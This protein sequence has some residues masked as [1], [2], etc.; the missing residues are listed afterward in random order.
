MSLKQIAAIGLTIATTLAAGSALAGTK[1]TLMYTASA[2]FASA[3]VAKDQGFF[4]KHG[5]DVEMKLVQNGSVIITGVASGSA[6][7]GIPTP[8]VAFQAIDNGIELQSFA[9]TNAFP[10]TS[11]A[12]LVVSEKS[13]IFKPSDMTGKKIGVPGVG[14]LLDVVM[15]QWVDANGGNSK[16]INIVEISLPQTGDMLR[17][18]QVDGVAAVDPFAT[19]AVETGAGRLI[20]NYFDVIPTGTAAGIFVTTEAWAKANPEAIKGM[21]L[22]L[23]EA[24]NYIKSNDASARDSLAKYTTLPPAVVAKLTWPN[25]STHLTPER[26][27]F[28]KTLSQE[29]G[30]ITGD[31]DLEAFVIPYPGK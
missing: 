8:T 31:I 23:D 2:P 24:I 17:A 15:R 7:V 18:G 10:D 21:Q 12:G 6:Q 20:G 1:V 11:A 30:L 29:Q 5:V 4:E 19:R 26:L 3:F 22:A 13:G 27:A 25:F 28:W 9:S 14:G 16:T